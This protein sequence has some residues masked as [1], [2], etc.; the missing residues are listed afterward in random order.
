MSLRLGA[1]EQVLQAVFLLFMLALVVRSGLAVVSTEPFIERLNAR[2]VNCRAYSAGV[3]P[4]SP[5]FGRSSLCSRRHVSMT[6]W[7]CARLVNQR[8]LRHSSRR[9]PL[10]D[11]MYAFCVVSQVRSVAA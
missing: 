3:S 10:N 11:S 5:F 7:A 1:Y 6:T 4:P 9:R 8:S 2:A